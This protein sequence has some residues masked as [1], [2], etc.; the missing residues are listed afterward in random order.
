MVDS[1]TSERQNI[2][3]HVMVNSVNPAGIKTILKSFLDT[4]KSDLQ[5]DITSAFW[6]LQECVQDEFQGNTD[7]NPYLTL[8]GSPDRAC[9]MSCLEYVEVRWGYSG[10]AVL[11][12]L[13]N[14]LK[15]CIAEREGV[16]EGRLPG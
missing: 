2:E 3:Q 10:R 4:E 11:Q 8:S 7:S 1:N 15:K 12:C 13:Q 16:E 5:T 9:A 14:T 6:E